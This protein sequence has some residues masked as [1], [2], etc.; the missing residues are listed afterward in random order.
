MDTEQ[1]THSNNVSETAAEVQTVAV[2]RHPADSYKGSAFFREN[3]ATIFIALISAFVIRTFFFEPFNIPSGSMFP[4]LEIGDY[5]FVSKYSYGYSGKTVPFLGMV[6]D[7]RVGG[8]PPE[9][10]DVAIFKLPSDPRIDYIKRI[11][12]LPGDT[13][14][15][16]DGRLYINGTVVD[17]Q[18]IADATF[19]NKEGRR[20]TYRQYIETLPNGLKHRILE[21]SDSEPLDNTIPYQVPDGY[22][23]AMGDNRDQSQDSRVL[24]KVGFIPMNNLVGKAG[25]LFM[26]LKPEAKIW[27]IWKWPAV[28]RYDRLLKNV[29]G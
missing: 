7:E 2:S 4:T 1:D 15:V 21:L 27:E 14:Q 20:N 23:F 8:S 9:Q 25:M 26:S 29:N 28:I 18:R 3:L 22:V 10:G 6:T 17:R 5:L 12:G 19:A 24:D 16:L 13:I 11:I